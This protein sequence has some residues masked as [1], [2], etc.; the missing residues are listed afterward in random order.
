MA[1]LERLNMRSAELDEDLKE[2]QDGITECEKII[3]IQNNSTKEEV[4]RLKG[5]SWWLI[6][7]FMNTKP[8]F[9]VRPRQTRVDTGP[10]HVEGDESQRG[11]GSIPLRWEVFRLDTLC[12]PCPYRFKSHNRPNTTT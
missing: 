12:K 1:K 9:R 4:F 6:S 2:A 10:P 8:T 7:Y 5:A 11:D 3:Q